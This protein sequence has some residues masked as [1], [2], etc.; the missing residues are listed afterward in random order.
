MKEPISGVVSTPPKSQTTA[1]IAAPELAAAAPTPASATGPSDLVVAEALAPL[2]RPAEEGDPRLQ[3]V[4]R[5][6]DRADQR[7]GAAQRPAVL[8]VEPQLHRHPPL[9]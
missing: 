2:D 8:G 4:R 7:A 3:A 9:H 6:D 1:S 5:G